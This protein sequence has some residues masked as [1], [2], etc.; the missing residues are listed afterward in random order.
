MELSQSFLLRPALDLKV[1]E[2]QQNV[3]SFREQ[4]T[5]AADLCIL[6]AW[7]IKTELQNFEIIRE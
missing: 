6:P 7:G 3:F 2:Q 4:R 5:W 1:T